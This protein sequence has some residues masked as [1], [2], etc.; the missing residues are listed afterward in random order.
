MN[1]KKEVRIKSSWGWHLWVFGAMFTAGMSDANEI[2][3]FFE[4]GFWSDLNFIC[5]W[6]IFY[7]IQF[8][9]I[10]VELLQK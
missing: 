1:E 7:P 2:L 5:G 4:G 9:N 10:I 3:R 8:G 6:I